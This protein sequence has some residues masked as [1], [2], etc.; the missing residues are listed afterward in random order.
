VDDDDVDRGP[1]EMSV[2]SGGVHFQFAFA[3][4]L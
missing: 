4:V 1:K 2:T 3:G